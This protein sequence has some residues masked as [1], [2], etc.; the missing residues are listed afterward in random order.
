MRKMLQAARKKFGLGWAFWNKP[1]AKAGAWL[2][3]PRS[4]SP[5]P[6]LASSPRMPGAG[7]KSDFPEVLEAVKNWFTA[8]HA[9][10][11]PVP[12]DLDWN[13]AKIGVW[14]T[15]VQQVWQSQAG[16]AGCIWQQ[17]AQEFRKLRIRHLMLKLE[18]KSLKPD[19]TTKLS[20]WRTNQGSP[21]LAGFWPQL[22]KACFATVSALEDLVCQPQQFRD[23]VRNLALIFSDRY[24]SGSRW[25]LRRK[26]LQSRISNPVPQSELRELL[27]LHYQQIL[28]IWCTRSVE[29]CSVF[30]KFC[31]GE[32]IWWLW[33][34]AEKES[35]RRCPGPFLGHLWGEARGL[36]VAML[37]LKLWWGLLDTVWLLLLYQTNNWNCH[38][39]VSVAGCYV[40]PGGWTFIEGPI[41]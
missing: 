36:L 14:T 24:L 39:C 28:G 16:A 2:R 12:T 9:I 21:H 23:S 8:S 18:A 17:A 33:P 31:W 4:I 29:A 35:A 27:S 20:F 6:T 30:G 25:V 37:T 32:A 11:E 13:F 38:Q 34:T 22:S 3:L 1:G 40:I 10:A 26:S 15:G 41:Q 7:R 19:L 5:V